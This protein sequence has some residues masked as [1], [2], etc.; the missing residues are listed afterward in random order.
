[1][2]SLQIGNYVMPLS[3][4]WKGKS[5]N[6]YRDSQLVSGLFPGVKEFAEWCWPLTAT[7]RQGYKAST[8]T[9]SFL[10]VPVWHVIRWEDQS[11]VVI[12]YK[13]LHEKK[14][15]L[16]SYQYLILAQ[17]S[18]SVKLQQV[19]TRKWRHSCFE[20]KTLISI[21]HESEISL[22]KNSKM[23]TNEKN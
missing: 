2:F 18:Y 14:F 15:F 5:F 17:N 19:L 6:K 21:S 22:K 3:V 10:S 20:T 1:M 8:V 12:S 23:F 11:E 9:S 7:W 13:W 16:T 4:F